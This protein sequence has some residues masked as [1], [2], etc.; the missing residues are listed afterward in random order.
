MIDHIMTRYLICKNYSGIDEVCH[1]A[2]PEV[3][4]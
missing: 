3:V 1:G 4:L 2:F